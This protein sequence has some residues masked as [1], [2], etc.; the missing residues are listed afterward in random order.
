[1]DGY[2]YEPK[3]TGLYLKLKKKGDRAKIR[4]T[5]VPIHFQEDFEGK[6]NERFAWVVIDKTDP[7]DI[8]A[9]AF[10]A[11]VM[12][13]KLIKELALNEDWGDPTGYDLTITRTEEQGNYYTLTPSP[14]KSPLSDDEKQLV[15]DA[16]INLQT[17]FKVDVD[18]GTKTF[19]D[20]PEVP[21][22]FQ[23]EDDLFGA[24]PF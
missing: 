14:N 15:K 16:D 24:V 18:K 20:S 9:R 2:D 19:G 12:V 1:M 22:D 4:L 11:G 3:D 8:R 17:M 7:K 23:D 6:A 10:K 21:G 13:Y 5:S